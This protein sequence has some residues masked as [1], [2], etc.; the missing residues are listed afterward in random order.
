M[1][2]LLASSSRRVRTRLQSSLAASRAAPS[3]AAAPSTAAAPPPAP[4]R[5][6]PFKSTLSFSPRFA[7]AQRNPVE[8]T[9]AHAGRYYSLGSPEEVRATFPFGFAGDL[10]VEFSLTGTHSLLIRPVGVSLVAQLEHW[11]QTHGRVL[12]AG[13]APVLDIDAAAVYAPPELHQPPAGGG[14]SSAGGTPS[15]APH[16]P[17]DA[18]FRPVRVLTGPRGVGKSGVLNYVVHYARASRAWI[19]VLVPSGFAVSH[20]GKVL[21]QTRR[22]PGDVDQHDVAF[23]ILREAARANGDRLSKVR[24]R[25]R[26]AAYRYLPTA[27]DERVSKEREA[28]RSAEV[29]EKAKLRAQAEASG[30]PWDPRA[31]KSK[32]EDESYLSLDRSSFTLSDMVTWGLRHPAAASDTLIDFLS[33]LRAVTEYPVLIAVD[34][35][36]HLYSQ[37]PYHVGG[38]P[39]PPERLSVQSAFH[40]IGSDGFKESFQLKRGLWLLAVS[41]KHSS[42][43]SEMF[44]KVRVGDRY[45]LP[46]PPLGRDELH[47]TLRYY[48]ATGAFFMLQG[49]CARVCECVVVQR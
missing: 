14:G 9:F 23:S 8:H 12:A 19:T 42:N 48:A 32:Y 46:I 33:E 45:R 21:A 36:N 18:S 13:G 37:G 3:S 20:M 41:H 38:L 15:T 34:G 49:A 25:G 27:L 31:F 39:V 11:R 1:Q 30:V 43:M 10:G 7:T 47:S 28:L 44:G 4:T 22:R 29:A 16:H 2:A 17:H 35:I 6:L 40:C 26:Y 5:P 24:Q